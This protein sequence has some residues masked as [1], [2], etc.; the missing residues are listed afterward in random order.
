MEDK[1]KFLK[2]FFCGLC[3]TVV[4]GG[5]AIYV[6]TEFWPKGGFGKAQGTGAMLKEGNILDVDMEHVEGKVDE[7]EQIVNQYYLDDIDTK[8]VE[9]Q[10]YKGMIAGLGDKYADY[11]TEEELEKLQESTSGVYMGIGATLTQDQETG[12]VSI[13]RCYEGTPA[14]EAG[15]LPGD[16]V[17]TIN[18]LEVTGMDLSSVVARIK[19]EEGETV[20]ISVAREGESD[21]LDLHVERREVEIPTVSHEMLDGKVGY[22]SVSS[23]DTVTESQFLE[24]K[25]DLENQGMEKLVIDLRYN[26]GGVMQAACNMLEQLLPKGL[27]VYTEDKNG[28]RS[29]YVSD[30]KHAFDKP[31][32][33]LVNEYSA[34][35]SEIF[36]GAVKDY[37]IGTLVGTKTYGKGIVQRVFSLED[38]TAVKMTIA[39]YYTPKGN[40][41]HG[42]GIVPDVEVELDESLKQKTVITREDDNQLQKALEVLK[43]K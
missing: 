38:G 12:V 33:L 21:Y 39:K 26:L 18:D 23:F 5:L 29:E 30:G 7:I 2:G 3:M 14:E 13:V 34:S 22:I 17:Y 10:I 1:K 37:G 43:G 6:K 24:A 20:K 15:L 25:T 19:T 41:I 40:D 35:A 9:T 8:E 42:V 27:V 28:E 4:V 36:A 31:L 16:K 11:F 32:V